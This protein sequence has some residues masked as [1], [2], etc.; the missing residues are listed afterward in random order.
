M[1]MKRRVL[2]TLMACMMLA[3]CGKEAQNPKE[4]SQAPET[5]STEAPTQ[6]AADME[7][8]EAVK[9]VY[10]LPD[11]TMENLTDAI[12]SV[13]L[14]EGDVYVDDSG[15]LQ[16]DV[17]IYTYDKFDMVDI[18]VLNPGDH[19]VTCSNEIEVNYM[20]RIVSNTRHRPSPEGRRYRRL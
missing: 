9:S 6:T 1:M 5:L 12:L 8:T 16:M 2:F 14:E 3:G 4:D 7:S 11:H 10:P 13:S 18:S 17:K 20:E 19:L 15:Q